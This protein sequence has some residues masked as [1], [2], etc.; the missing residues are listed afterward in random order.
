[1]LRTGYERIIY[2][3]K[4]DYNTVENLSQNDLYR[5]I[6]LKYA[7]E[8]KKSLENCCQSIYHFLDIDKFERQE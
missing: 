7:E 1:M 2:L 4:G 3:V 6:V 5:N 8:E